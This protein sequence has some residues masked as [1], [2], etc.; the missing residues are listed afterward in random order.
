MQSLG[1]ACR[2]AG[3]KSVL[4]SRWLANDRST[5]VIIGNFYEQLAG[6]KVKPA[7]LQQAKLSYLEQADALTA[8]PF[9]WAGL[10]LEGEVGS[11]GKA[12]TLKRKWVWLI[13]L[14]ILLAGMVAYW[15]R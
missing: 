10:A 9:F 1:S 3:C 2:Y 4:A 12:G 15:Q 14:L 6:G 8:H 5:A 7:A 13:G 11:I